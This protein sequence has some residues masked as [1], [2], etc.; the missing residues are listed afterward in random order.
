MHN[1]LAELRPTVG[2]SNLQPRFSELIDRRRGCLFSIQFLSLSN[3]TRILLRQ[4][5]QH[6]WLLSDKPFFKHVR[7]RFPLRVRDLRIHQIIVTSQMATKMLS[8]DGS[9]ATFDTGAK[10]VMMPQLGSYLLIDA[11]CRLKQAKLSQDLTTCLLD[12]RIVL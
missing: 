6:Y 10:A 9:A 7:T 5:G 3:R 1:L 12:D 2:I 11:D 8:A 4:G